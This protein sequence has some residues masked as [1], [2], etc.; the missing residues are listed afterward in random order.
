MND[1]K[2]LGYKVVKDTDCGIKLVQITD[3]IFLF[4]RDREMVYGFVKTIPSN[5]KNKSKRA[6]IS[7]VLGVSIWFSNVEASEAI[8]LSIRPTHT[9]VVRVQPSYQHDSKVQIAKLIPRKKDLIVYKSPKEILFLMPSLSK[10]IGSVR[11]KSD[12][13]N[14]QWIKEFVS[15]IRGGDNEKLIKSIISKVSEDDWDIPSINKL[16][17]KLAEVTL[18]IGSNDKLMRIL[19]EL[20]KP[21]AVSPLFVEVE[22]WV[23]QLPRHRKLNEVEKNKYSSPSIEFLLDS[24]KCYGHRE[25][26]NMPRSVSELF[27]TNAV[28]NLAKISLKNPRVNKEYLEIK[29]QIE[30]GVHPVNLSNKSTYISSTKVLVKKPEGRYI[31]D[32]SDTE[33]QIVGVSS[34]TNKKSM[35]KFKNLMN[36]LYDLN[37]EGY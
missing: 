25:A 3:S 1:R 13:R 36:K 33:A 17:K 21:I 27:E 15:G 22:G 2:Q 34:R 9:P 28:K 31:V 23:T 35:G 20:E 24:T 26:Y 10:S 14:S 11:T 4:T 6:I 12:L 7:S 18:E 37:L 19:A 29:A 5:L 30:Q 8:G 16:L 32:V